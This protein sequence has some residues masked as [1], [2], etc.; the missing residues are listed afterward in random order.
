MRASLK[1]IR[2]PLAVFEGEI[3]VDGE[4]TA[5][6]EEI[7]LTYDYYPTVHGATQEVLVKAETSSSSNGN[8]TNG[9]DGRESLSGHP[10]DSGAKSP[11]GLGKT[12][13]D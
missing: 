4:K 5:S 3:T 8:G 10:L 1:R 13:A 6:A 11:R 12:L 9:K 2:H 7:K